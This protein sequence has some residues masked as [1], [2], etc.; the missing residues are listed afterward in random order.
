MM[1]K[2][3]ISLEDSTHGYKLA[4]RA[5]LTG[6]A[7]PFESC[8]LSR[9]DHGPWSTSQLTR[10]SSF[11]PTQGRPLA[12]PYAR[13]VELMVPQWH[14]DAEPRTPFEPVN[15]IHVHS[16]TMQQIFHPTSESRHFTR[17]DAAKAFGEHILPA[18]QRIPLPE[19]VNLERDLLA[20]KPMH[21]ARQRFD[22]DVAAS[23]QAV[24]EEFH[25][26][27]R[28][29][30]AQTTRVPTDRFEFRVVDYNS[31]KVGRQGRA[32][33]AVGWRYGY[34]HP[35]RKVGQVKIPTKVE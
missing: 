12:K 14:H 16:Y 17:A 22:A 20:G 26:K 25:H 3:S 6:P 30:E 15:E 23:E 19:L 24:A 9:S 7:T 33:G 27:V 29:A 4:L 13:A 2:N 18:D 31:Q 10:P 8:H 32:R 1:Y 5:S 28:L 35:D 34:P 21:E 11:P